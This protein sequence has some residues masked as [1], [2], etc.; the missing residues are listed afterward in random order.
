MNRKDEIKFEILS[1]I[2]DRIIEEQTKKRHRLIE[3]PRYSRKKLMTWI[4]TAA[5]FLLFF[6]SLF[7]LIPL[8]QKQV[9]VYQGMTVSHS[10]PIAQEAA[11]GP[12]AGPGQMSL[13]FGDDAYAALPSLKAPGRALAASVVLNRER[14]GAEA[15]EISFPEIEGDDRV[16]YYA[17]KNEDIYITIH[18]NNPASFEILSFT[19]NGEKYQAFMF[20]DGSNSEELVLKVNVGNTEGIVAYT[21]DAIKYI[22]GTEIKDVR[23]DG[24]KTVK[25]GVYPENQPTVA[26]TDKTVDYEMF[27]VAATLSDAL[28]MIEESEGKL[29]VFLYDGA[30]QV[31]SKEVPIGDVITA[32]FT[33]LTAGGRYRYE[34][35][36]Y[37]DAFDGEGFGAYSLYGED[38]YAKSHVKVENVQLVSNQISFGVSK[39]EGAHLQKV[40]LLDQFGETV[41]TGNAET[42]SFAGILPGIY[43]VRVTYAYG[44]GEAKHGYAY[45]TEV[46][47]AFSPGCL[48]SITSVVIGGRVV[49]PYSGEEMIYNPTTDDFR[50]HHGV[51]VCP[52]S[53]N[54]REVYAAFGGV[55]KEVSPDSGKVVIAD[56]DGNVEITY[57][58]LGGISVT[59]GST[60]TA[61]QKIGTVGSTYMMEAADEAHVH[62]ELRVFGEQKDPMDY[63]TE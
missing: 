14:G 26:V 60:V 10:R 1:N 61:G 45:S 49:R 11:D 22:D 29:F 32:S 17:K 20:E 21:I 31:A 30:E 36:A 18:I 48:G 24:E 57:M 13:A 28:G 43:T 44:D 55:V 34:I 47:L 62:I 25:V 19:L 15:A 63:F 52:D 56:K 42:R 5:S 3:K 23:M 27:S 8:F 59:K 2:D 39:G 6:S 41:V 53:Q 9:P 33:G 12:T 35:V 37:Y 7:V 4:A 50:R 16:L 54:K 40:E 58:S 38:F 51:D 46:E